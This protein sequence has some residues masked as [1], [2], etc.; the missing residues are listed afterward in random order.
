[1]R[2]CR[3]YNRANTPCPRE[4]WD[5]HC[6]PKRFCTQA[7]A[8]WLKFWSMATWAASLISSPAAKPGNLGSDTERIKMQIDD[9][10]AAYRIAR[11]LS[12]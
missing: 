2:L 3:R 9:I 10:A 12:R 4:R 5:T 8:Y 7:I 1:V 11:S 6:L